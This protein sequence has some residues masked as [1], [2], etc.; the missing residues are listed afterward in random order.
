M[1]NRRPTTLVETR[2]RSKT[3]GYVI[4]LHD[5][6]YAVFIA[7]VTFLVRK[8]ETWEVWVDQSSSPVFL[9]S[10]FRTF[11]DAQT[12]LRER[13]D[14]AWKLWLKGDPGGTYRPRE[15]TLDL[16]LPLEELKRKLAAAAGGNWE[17]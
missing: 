7:S 17:E 2:H 11:R 1:F 4:T 9:R 12:F 3:R 14:R 15:L 10:G 5:P 6:R 13:T 8:E 16:N